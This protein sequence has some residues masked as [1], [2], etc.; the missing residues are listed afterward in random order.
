MPNDFHFQ[1]RSKQKFT[2][3]K[4]RHINPELI[5]SD[6]FPNALDDLMFS[7]QSTPN[8]HSP[9]N[10]PRRSMRKRH[11]MIHP[12]TLT[13]DN[14]SEKMKIKEKRK[15]TAKF[16]L[17]E[18]I[19]NESPANEYFPDEIVFATIPGYCP[20]PASILYIEGQTLFVKFFGTGQM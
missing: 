11:T 3:M 15:G 17:V 13:T 16:S 2:T 9:E 4:N 5:D 20:W 6:S 14:Q 10:Q 8:D 1:R 19:N 12:K 7:E 18:R